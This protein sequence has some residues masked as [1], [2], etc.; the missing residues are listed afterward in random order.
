MTLVVAGVSG[1]G[2]TTLARAVAEA[3]GAVFLDA[4]DLH[5]AQAKAAMAAGVPLTDADRWPWL[6]RVRDA[7]ADSAARGESL[8]VACSALRRAYRAVLAE[9]PGVTFVLLDLP[10]E[11]L[12]A[13][14]RARTEHFMPAGLLDSQLATLEPPGPGEQ[15][16][17]VDGTAPV[18]V[19]VRTVVDGLRRPPAST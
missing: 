9:A 8:V 10:A 5:S 3:T 14:L 7:I 16:L 17:V 1:S 4:D 18:D 2:K 19:L 6:A 11:V 12:G 15:V 13:R